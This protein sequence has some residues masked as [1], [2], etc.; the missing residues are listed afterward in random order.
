LPRRASSAHVLVAA[1]AVVT[2]AAAG[3]HRHGPTTTTPVAPDA[4]VLVK[5]ADG[6][7]ADGPTPT[8]AVVN[9]RGFEAGQATYEFVVTAEPD[10]AVVEDIKDVPAG[11]VQTETASSTPLDLGRAYHWKAV[12]HAGDRQVESKTGAFDVAVPCLP[13]SPYAKS[14]VDLYLTECTQRTNRRALLNPSNVLGPP[15]ARGSSD[16]TYA[17]ILSLGQDGYV[18]VDMGVCIADQEGPDLRVFQYVQFEGV[19]VDVSGSPG[20]PWVDLGV[21]PCGDGGTGDN[22]NHC[23]FDLAGTGLRTARYVRVSDAENFPCERAGTRSEGADIDAVQALH[24][25]N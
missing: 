7:T 16:A 1:A 6:A 24:V 21:K 9:A 18:T 14:V 15:D 20:G 25:R 23:D 19:G 10:G 22:S 11:A 4:P 13:G 17:G 5:P 12:A 2:A 8:F 3:C